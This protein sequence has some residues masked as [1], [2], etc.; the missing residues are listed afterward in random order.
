[1]AD[2]LWL[3]L[4]SF[5]FFHKFYVFSTDFWS[6]HTGIWHFFYSLHLVLMYLERTITKKQKTLLLHDFMTSTKGIFRFTCFNSLTYLLLSFF[7]IFIYKLKLDHI[8]TRREYEHACG[9]VVWNHYCHVLQQE[10][11]LEFFIGGKIWIRIC[12]RGNSSE[13]LPPFPPTGIQIRIL[14]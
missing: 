13:S 11:G 14:W 5:L 1:L 12:W 10:S 7:V 3:I 2:L 8:P 9:K 6:K 4:S